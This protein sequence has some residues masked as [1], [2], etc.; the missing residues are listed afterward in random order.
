MTFRVNLV[1]QYL[2][3][4]WCKFDGGGIS[5]GGGDV[6]GKRE[7]PTNSQRDDSSL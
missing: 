2:T 5:G 4:I 7:Q 3:S 1:I 6:V